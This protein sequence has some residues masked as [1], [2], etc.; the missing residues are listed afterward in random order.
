MRATAIWKGSRTPA[1]ALAGFGIVLGLVLVADRQAGGEAT[2]SLC[3]RL[4]IG[5]GPCDHAYLTKAG[6][7]R[8]FA[9]VESVSALADRAN[10]TFADKLR[11]AGAKRLGPGTPGYQPSAVRTQL[12]DADA[13]RTLIDVDSETTLHVSPLDEAAIFRLLLSDPRGST[14]HRVST[15]S[16]DPART[17]G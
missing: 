8:V 3:S 10:P 15:A 7:D 16:S 12:A 6:F 11:L 2:A 4:D 1:I 14:A 17:G 13:V 5:D 9:E